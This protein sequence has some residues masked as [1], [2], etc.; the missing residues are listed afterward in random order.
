MVSNGGTILTNHP[1]GFGQARDCRSWIRCV[2][3][4]GWV[5]AGSGLPSSDSVRL[6]TL[7]GLGRLGI[8]AVGFGASRSLGGSGQVQDCRRRIQWV[9][10]VR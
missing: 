1:R 6:T 8:A 2:S 4:L 10:V 9:G 5:W 7:M 3:E